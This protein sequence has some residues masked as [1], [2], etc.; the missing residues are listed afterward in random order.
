MKT[1]LSNN[2]GYRDPTA[3]RAIYHVMREQREKNRCLNGVRKK[4][5]KSTAKKSSNGI[6]ID[7]GGKLK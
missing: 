7:M 1:E 4:E 5:R 2:E 3:D 6:N